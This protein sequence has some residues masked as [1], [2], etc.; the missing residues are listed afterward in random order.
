[1]EKF[2]EAC[3]IAII[4]FILFVIF[5]F[6]YAAIGCWLWSAVMVGVFGLPTLTYWQMYA[7][8]W[9]ARVIFPRGSRVSTS[10]D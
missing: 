7:L 1:M 4:T 8:I 2:G 3:L 9:L 6:I 10:K 5:A